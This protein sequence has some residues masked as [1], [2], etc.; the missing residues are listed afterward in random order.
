MGLNDNESVKKEH[1]FE[2]L[3]AEIVKL[4]KNK[5]GQYRNSPMNILPASY[6]LN[7]IAIKAIRAEQATS[8]EKVIEELTDTAVYALMTIL[9]IRGIAIE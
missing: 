5:N 2:S 4:H 7:Q 8:D 9:R 6:W 1:T 3:C